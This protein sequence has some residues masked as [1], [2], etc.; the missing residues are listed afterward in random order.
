MFAL[1]T[2]AD[3]GR[4][5]SA[6]SATFHARVARVGVIT[7]VVVLLAACLTFMLQQ[8]VVARSQS[9]RIHESLAG[10]TAQMAAPVVD[11]KPDSK[12][13]LSAV[14]ASPEVVSARLIGQSGQELA[15]YERA[16]PAGRDVETFDMPV[17]VDGQPM[18][19]LRMVVERPRLQPMLAKFIALTAVLL[20]GGVGVALFLSRSLAHRVIQPVQALSHAM[21]EVAAGGSFTPVDVEAGDALFESLTES[22]N[23]LLTKLGEREQELKRTMRELESARDAANAA[24][25]LKTQFLA[26]MSHEIRTPLNGVLAM[27][28]VMALGDLEPL[29]RERLDVIRRSGGL[30]LAVLND[31]LDLSKIEAGK[32]TLLDEDFELGPELEQVGENFRVIAEGKGLAFSVEVGETARGWWR[33]DADRLRQIVGNLLSN[34]VKFTTQGEVR[35]TVDIGETGAL[36]IVVRDTGV[37]IAP[38]KLPSLFEKFT[39]ADNSA[40]RRFGGTGLGLA[41]CRELTQMMGGSI[42]VESREGHGSTFTVELPLKRGQ[43]A[44]AA[45]AEVA[46]ASDDGDL[47]LLAAEDNPT[48]QQVLAAVLGSLGIDVHIVPDG[49]EA[50]EAWR[51]GAYDLILMDIQMPVMDGITAAREIRS[52]EAAEKRARTPIVALTANALTHQVEEYLAVGMDAHVAKPIEIAKLYDAISAALN[53]VAAAGA[54]RGKSAAA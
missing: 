16:R 26:N 6:P 7:T 37:G 47:R 40:T 28:E 19:Q 34:A 25:V 35:A 9:H 3:A 17:L 13:A 32:L 8:W 44:E 33:G 36:R 41:I 45:P 29:Q 54:S 5:G 11:N 53:A 43:P 30:L 52:L 23:H 22:F 42:D 14:Q 50:V 38:E 21:H 46:P 20:F 39:Q 27:A 51:A 15:R 49:K 1:R 18:G 10:I 24:N 2:F 4:K 48:N 31:V 12:A